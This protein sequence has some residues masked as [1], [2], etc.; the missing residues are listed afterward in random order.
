MTSTIETVFE[1]DG[2]PGVVHYRAV[3]ASGV[4]IPGER[5]AVIAV[6]H[7]NEPAGIP[8][9]ERLAREVHTELVAGELLCVRSNLEA[10]AQNLRHTPDGRDLNRL[11]DPANLARIA[12]T[13]PERLCYE[14]R[15]AGELAP[16]LLEATAVLDLHSTSRPAAP[17]L[18]FRDDQRHAQMARKLGVAHLVTGLHENAILSGGAC[19]NVGLGPGKHGDRL[20]LTFEAGQ[21]TDPGNGERAFL[22][23]WRLLH[24]LG[25]WRSVP[26]PSD[27]VSEV[28]EVTD[29]F[30][31]TEGEPWRF[32][33]YA[34]GE[35]G[36]GRRGPMRQ[37]HSFEQVEADEV[38][39][40]RGQHD[41]VRAQFPFTMLMPAPTTP[42]GTDLY[43][44]TEPR[45]GGLTQ[46]QAR[47]DAEARSEALAI[48][49]MLDL[50]ADDDFVTGTS[51]VAF[52]TRR[53]FDLCGSVIGRNLRLPPGHPHRR[54]LVMGRGDAPTDDDSHRR[55]TVRYRRAMQLAMRE[56]IPL[57]RI[58]LLRGASLSW[59]DALTSPGM[60]ELFAQRRANV[61]SEHD[62]RMRISLRQ[63]H[64]ASML[65]AGDLGLALATGDTRHVR[66]ALLVEAATVEPDGPGVRVRVMRTG[67]VSSRHEVLVSAKR[68][69]DALRDEHDYDVK[70]G[71]LRDARAVKDL[72]AP[73][74]ALRSVPDPETLASLRHALYRVQL[75]LWCDQLRHELKE[76]VVLSDEAALGRWLASTMAATGILD[77]DGLHALAVRRRGDGWVADPEAVASLE[78]R[79]HNQEQ[80][81]PGV[82][83]GPSSAHTPRQPLM[84]RDVSAD[85][86]ER[87]VGWKRFVRGVRSVPDTRGKD[88][89]LAFSGADIRE[90]LC[91]WYREA[92]EHARNGSAEVLVVLAGDGLSPHRDLIEGIDPL[93]EAPDVYVAHDA[94]LREPRLHY[95]R[96]QHAQG[97]YL[98]WMKDFVRTLGE[99]PADSRPVGLQWEVE[100][101]DTVSIVLVATRQQPSALVGHGVLEGWEIERCAVVVSDLK[102]TGEDYEIGLFTEPMDAAASNQELLAFGRAH[103]SGLMA[104][105]GAR[106]TT[107]G[108]APDVREV[109]EVVVSQ[110]A[111]WIER[112]RV[113]SHTSR[114]VPEDLVERARW[115]G[116]RLGL[117][118]PELA[119]G[120]AVEMQGDRDP[121]EAAWMLWEGVTP[122]PGRGSPSGP[123]H[124]GAFGPGGPGGTGGTIA[125]ERRPSARE[126]TGSRQA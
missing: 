32:V 95:L 5:V 35:P 64:T 34:G 91:R 108:G 86:L 85:D 45:H 84:A 17:F 2:V 39:L 12:R 36:G 38:L 103:C 104:Q 30:V 44:I 65:V 100:H 41:V 9:L 69:I 122:W 1:P 88:F 22:V 92:A 99:R 113:W 6:T 13:P 3:D 49:R 31:Q 120:L 109:E 117:A 55:D 40:R 77:A 111:R 58:Q 90:R 60:V 73:D 74:G 18:V 97:T 37:L 110:I 51:W 124:G 57:E 80:V 27:V 62:V 87:W 125:R 119:R 75:G 23:V 11:W 59:L 68:L 19:A 7:G 102:S 4:A 46:G 48:E 72:L 47:S 29:R 114:T 56:G 70:N 24:D 112:V 96:I 14:E 26:P 116:H 121:T 66:V 33:G 63:P 43:Y 118:D 83:F 20:G 42:A 98:S 115:V 15:R 61:G 71:A 89:D 106:V 67:L 76:P 10:S 16:L 94:L 126:S 21:H 50:L 105:A 79:L 107:E 25:V 28:F 81:V 53:L 123:D 82:L 52:D 8:V 101:G 93:V 54:L 78:A